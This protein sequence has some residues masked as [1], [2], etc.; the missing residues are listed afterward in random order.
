MSDRMGMS[1]RTGAKSRFQI[2]VWILDLQ[3]YNNGLD[4]EHILCQHRLKDNL[5][6][7]FK[8]QKKQKKKHLLVG[9]Q[10]KVVA[11]NFLLVV[12]SGSRA[13]THTQDTAAQPD[14]Y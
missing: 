4:C 1:G 7:F 11:K 2:L 3:R 12:P 6:L 14:F 5:K 8:L 10:I 9:V 13:F